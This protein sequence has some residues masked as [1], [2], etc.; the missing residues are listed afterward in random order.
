M[1]A[2]GGNPVR[3]TNDPAL[4][5]SPAFSPTGRA[6]VFHTNHDGNNELY[7]MGIDGSGLTRLTNEPAFD[8]FASWA[9]ARP[10]G[11]RT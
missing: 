3:L 1:D 9:M 11:G 7:V 6:L 10:G 4:D 2:D 8:G 5:A